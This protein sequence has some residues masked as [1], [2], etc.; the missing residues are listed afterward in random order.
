MITSRVESHVVR[1]EVALELQVVIDDLL[2]HV[3][4]HPSGPLSG[5][6]QHVGV[7]VTPLQAR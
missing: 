4:L 6:Y 7:A 2:Q 5:L 3:F 1:R